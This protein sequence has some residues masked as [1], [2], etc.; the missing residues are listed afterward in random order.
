MYN[1]TLV[2]IHATTWLHLICINKHV[3]INKIMDTMEVINLFSNKRLTRLIQLY[4][5]VIAVSVDV[6]R[7]VWLDNQLHCTYR[8][9][10]CTVIL[11]HLQQ[12]H[13]HL[14]DL[15]PGQKSIPIYIEHFKTNCNTKRKIRWELT[16]SKKN[17]F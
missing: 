4:H 10:V 12:R 1:P 7:L 15:I 6:K 11:P 9:G 5:V 16:Y 17:F 3:H 14:M 8:E 2:H 13:H